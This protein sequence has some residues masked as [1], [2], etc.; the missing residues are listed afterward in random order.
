MSVSARTYT[1]ELKRLE[2]AAADTR[3]AKAEADARLREA[4]ADAKRADARHTQAIVAL[5]AHNDG[6]PGITVTDHAVVRYLERVGKM[7]MDAVRRHILP[8]GAEAAILAMP[9]ATSY[10]VGGGHRLKLRGRDVVT[11]T[12]DAQDED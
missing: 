8:A 6:H 11:V 9:G 5:K 12:T 2:Q 7:D 3:V 10:E 1:A 4:K